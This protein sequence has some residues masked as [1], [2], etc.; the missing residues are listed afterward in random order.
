[1]EWL[2]LIVA[3]SPAICEESLFRGV[4][5]SSLK[6]KLPTWATIGIVGLLFGL[7]HL[8]VYKVVPTALSGAFFAY[9]V[10]R[11][12]SIVCSAVAHAL[13][14]GLAILLETGNLPAFVTKSLEGLDIE[15]NGLPMTWVIVGAVLFVA[16]IA[17]V[18]LG[19]RRRGA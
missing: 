1:M 5:L 8:S 15:H 14:N 18:E 2:I 6:D 12:G 16:G 11:S 17:L 7:F 19:A 13:L 4:I 3:I 10:L 9:L